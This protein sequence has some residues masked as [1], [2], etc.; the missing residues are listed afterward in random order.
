MLP[1][2]SLCVDTS[3]GQTLN[4]IV[5][6]K[7]RFINGEG[8]KHKDRRPSGTSNPSCSLYWAKGFVKGWGKLICGRASGT[9]FNWRT[10]E[11]GHLW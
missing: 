3:K 5:W 10:L 4:I 8:A 2:H 9:S 6:S 7:K 1:K 11:L